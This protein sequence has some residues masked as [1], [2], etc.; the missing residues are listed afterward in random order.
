MALNLAPKRKLVEADGWKEAVPRVVPLLHNDEGDARLVA[1]LQ[2]LA[3]ALDGAHLAKHHVVELA[4]AHA[5]A[6]VDDLIRL[7]SAV[8]TL[9][10]VVTD[11]TAV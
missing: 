11:A 8:R 9:T 5:V 3:S 10:E 4:L 2:G 7:E 6:E 1:V